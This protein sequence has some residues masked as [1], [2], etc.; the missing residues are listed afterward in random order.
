MVSGAVLSILHRL[1]GATITGLVGAVAVAVWFL[2]VDA[3]SGRPFYTPAVLGSAATLGLRD[4]AD[5]VINLQ[6][7]GAYTAFHF[8]AF[9]AVGVV[10]AALAEEASRSI[11]VLWL[12]GPPGQEVFE[13]HHLRVGASGTIPGC[14]SS[15]LLYRRRQLLFNPS[16]PPC[17][18]SSQLRKAPIVCEQRQTNP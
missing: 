2:I 1:Q 12:V 16:I 9:F 14:T 3:L 10:A 7:V 11:D 18:W 4:P 15:R 5:V 13:R 17:R 8:L 6:S